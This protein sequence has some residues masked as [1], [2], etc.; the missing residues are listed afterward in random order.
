MTR[1]PVYSRQA[2]A[3]IARI[4]RQSLRQFGTNQ[5]RRYSAGIRKTCEGLAAGSL[6]GQPIDHIRRGYLRKLVQ[7]HYVIFRFDEN[8]RLLVVR[9]LH[10]R[11][12]LDDHL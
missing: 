7:S 11:M 1:A 12:R 9:I 5:A 3:D 10:S 6:R 8:G 4:Y 2:E